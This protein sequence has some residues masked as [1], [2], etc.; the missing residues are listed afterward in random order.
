MA[1]NPKAGIL[2]VD[3]NELIRNIVCFMLSRLGYMTISAHDGTEALDCMKNNDS[4]HLV[5]TDINMPQMDG[6]RLA[7]HIK[8]LKPD[9]PIVALTGEAPDAIIP[10]LLDSGIHQ[11]LFKPLKLE[12]LRDAVSSILQS[13][14]MKLAS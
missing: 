3:D 13:E 8:E 12:V 6:W 10:K 5:L 4:I 14:G 2:V 11:A 1:F 9:M 7:L